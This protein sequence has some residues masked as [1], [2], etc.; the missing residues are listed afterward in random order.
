MPNEFEVISPFDETDAVAEAVVEALAD[1]LLD[2][3]CVEI[4]ARRALIE[5]AEGLRHARA[6]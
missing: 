4:N 5:D 1:E 3:Q 2:A 6:L